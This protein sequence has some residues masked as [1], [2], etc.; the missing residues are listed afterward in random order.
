MGKAVSEMAGKVKD[1]CVFVVE[2]R[3]LGFSV[4]S[5]SM[6]FLVAVTIIVVRRKLVGAELGGPAV[7]K[8][9]SFVCFICMWIGWIYAVSWRVIRYD[10]MDWPEQIFMGSIVS[11]IEL[12]IASVSMF[13][14]V[15]HWRRN[16]RGKV[17]DDEPIVQK[18]VLDDEEAAVAPFQVLE[19][20]GRASLRSRTLSCESWLSAKTIQ[21][22]DTFPPEFV[23]KRA[24]TRISLSSA[25][26]S[27]A[28]VDQLDMAK[29]FSL[30]SSKSGMSKVESEPLADALNGLR[31]QV[32]QPESSGSMVT[33]IEAGHELESLD[34]P[35]EH[36]F[37]P[38]ANSMR[39]HLV[40][41]GVD[42]AR[43]GTPVNDCVKVDSGGNYLTDCCTPR[44]S[45]T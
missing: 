32:A 30:G 44:Q 12:A 29:C 39:P 4:M 17:P 31:S 24:R 8:W 43:M 3:N 14:I 7:P 40:S 16:K 45:R 36:A 26:G 5:F 23:I 33:M 20:G 2:S 35:A 38:V 6:A 1:K 19:S 10:Y 37:P 28:N 21:S 13:L 34:F 18:E 41:H 25:S 11:C 15:N 27:E 22:D 9:A 42:I